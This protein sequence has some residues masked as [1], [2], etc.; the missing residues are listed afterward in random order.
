MSTCP[1][2][3]LLQSYFDKQMAQHTVL[4]K[5]WKSASGPQ[6]VLCL[7]D[8]ANH[9]RETFTEYI[10]W[11]EE[12]LQEY[13]KVKRLPEFLAMEIV[14]PNEEY[15]RDY[16]EMLKKLSDECANR[17]IDSTALR[18]AI[19]GIGD[20]FNKMLELSPTE[21]DGTM[22]GRYAHA[23]AKLQGYLP[24]GILPK[25]ATDEVFAQLRAACEREIAQA[26]PPAVGKG[27]K[28]KPKRKTRRLMVVPDGFY[29]PTDVAVAIDPDADS[30][31]K[32]T[33]A[34][35]LGRLF[36]GNR[37]PG[38]AWMENNDPAKGQ[39]RILYRWSMVRPFLERYKPNAPA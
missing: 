14:G 18:A 3:E 16:G 7:M 5:L 27:G 26:M 34:V 36:K 2:N 11:F 15:Y 30:R 32:R 10:E 28:V 20:T 19:G 29:S 12:T 24:H 13:R 33:V 8:L 17:A 1:H 25:D 39:A 35:A 9:S 4:L 22:A 31:K 21:A 23:R 37:L 6:A 38:D